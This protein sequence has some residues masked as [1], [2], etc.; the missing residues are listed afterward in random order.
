MSLGPHS[1][2]ADDAEAEGEAAEVGDGSPLA[3]VLAAAEAVVVGVSADGLGVTLGEHAATATSRAAAATAVSHP[4]GPWRSGRSL[5]SIM[6][7]SWHT[8]RNPAVGG[9]RPDEGAH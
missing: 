2:M 7:R 3:G 5:E 4:G 8:I 6:A 9:S 1:A